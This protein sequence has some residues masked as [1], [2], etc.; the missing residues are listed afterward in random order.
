MIQLPVI[1]DCDPGADDSLGILLA[2]NNPAVTVL[3][4]TT[5]CGNAPAHQTA[6]NATKIL[7]LTGRE[8][9]MVY[10]GANQPMQR[11]LEF[12][13]LYSGA[14]GLCETDLSEKKELLSELSARE[15]LIQTLTA[16]KVPVTIIAT[17]GFTN[18][19]QALQE[20]PEIA[21]NI[22]EIVAPSG[23]YGLNKKEC[24][25]EWNILVDPEAA[26]IIYSSGIP[27]RAVGL[28]VTCM[29]E[30]SYVEHVL[31]QWERRG[32]K[33]CKTSSLC[34][35]SRRIYDFLQGCTSYN[36]RTGLSTYSLLVDGM[37]VA[38]VIL[39]EIASYVT[40]RV[41]VHPEKKD[42]GL[43]E[44]EPDSDGNVKAACEF[45]M[46]LYLDMVKGLIEE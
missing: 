46:T 3:G 22:C 36:K 12:S 45:N 42:A 15:Y 5:V 27:V 43:M 40:G 6:L 28:D 20:K 1:I 33:A 35:K 39:P 38:A 9:I 11:S 24:R 25:A 4:I 10:C 7:R 2:L 30:D 34:S 13:S 17:A 26:A 21:G 44:F 14:D 31:E 23:Y 16:T 8:D 32:D 19:A 18:V 37:A 29:L 41:T